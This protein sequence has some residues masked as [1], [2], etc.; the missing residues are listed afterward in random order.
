MKR[1]ILDK[2]YNSKRNIIVSGNMATGKTTNV[3]FPITDK[4]ISNKESFVVTDS[5]DEYLNKY[6]NYL[7]EKNYNCII[8]N[9]RDL[10]KSECWNPLEYAYNLYKENNQN[11]AIEYLYNLANS[12]FNTEENDDPFWQRTTCDFFVGVALALFEDAKKEEINLNSINKIITA[13]NTKNEKESPLTTYFMSKD[14][15]SQAYIN[16]ST[17]ILAPKDTK[18]SI[19]MVANQMIKPYIYNDTV[20]S[21]LNITTFDYKDILNKPTAIF[22]ITK[23][24]SKI[25]NS[26]ATSFIEELFNILLDN[27]NKFNFILDNI[28][29]I[30]YFNNLL[31]MMSQASPNHLK[32]YLGTR[33]IN[34]LKEKYND[35]LL[36]VSDQVEIIGESIAYT[37]NDIKNTIPNDNEEVVIQQS[38][39]EYPTNQIKK[40]Q[41]FNLEEFN[42]NTKIIKLEEMIKNTKKH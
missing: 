26:V 10:E 6:Y 12:F 3:L 42:K 37:I 16:A 28:D 4:I 25:M 11:K 7:K 21:L 2:L 24:E 13:T 30:R 31:D 32:F 41:I 20:S 17:T 22:V 8:L 34:N 40:I 1:E 5:K 18:G 38:I 14:K 23:K 9:L 27:Q 36:S 19:L 29:D 15:S 39:I 35:L 33:S